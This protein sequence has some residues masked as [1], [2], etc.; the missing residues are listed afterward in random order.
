MRLG[1]NIG[2]ILVLSA[3]WWCPHFHVDCWTGKSWRDWW[4]L[5]F[6]ECAH[7]I[8]WIVVLRRI[9]CKVG[10]NGLGWYYFCHSRNQLTPKCFL[11]W[12]FA[13]K[14]WYIFNWWWRPNNA[15][16]STKWFQGFRFHI[17]Y[18]A[19]PSRFLRYFNFTQGITKLTIVEFSW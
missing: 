17:F 4:C 19:K 11:W 6:P 16:I 18:W 2:F 1:W 10:F 14:I 5:S 13:I 8:V 3:W 9:C 12:K 7:V 15:T